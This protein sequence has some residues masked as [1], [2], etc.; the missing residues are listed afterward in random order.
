VTMT[1]IRA[2]P[3]DAFYLALLVN[4]WARLDDYVDGHGSGGYGEDSAIVTLLYTISRD[5]AGV[6]L[7]CQECPHIER[8]NAFHSSLGSQ[9]TQAALAMAEH[10]RIVHHKDATLTPLTKNY[11]RMEQW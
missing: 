7:T 11:G 2:I 3:E 4:G 6:I 9:R 1:T 10:N 8:V 5:C